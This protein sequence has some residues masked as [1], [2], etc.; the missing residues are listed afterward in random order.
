MPLHATLL[1]P[2]SL[3]LLC[4]CTLIPLCPYTLGGGDNSTLHAVIELVL[5]LLN[6][7]VMNVE[8][9]N[10]VFKS[11]CAL[12]PF[13]SHSLTPLCPCTLASLRPTSHL[14]RISQSDIVLVTTTWNC[15]KVIDEYLLQL[16]LRNNL[17]LPVLYP[18][19]LDVFFGGFYIK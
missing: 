7:E 18:D 14:V 19:V 5:N 6:S 3:S 12:A 2:H 9:M 11:S 13:C 17:C 1:Y 15:T 8:V 16:S 10:L 4:L